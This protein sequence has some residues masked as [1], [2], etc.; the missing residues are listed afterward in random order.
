MGAGEKKNV[1]CRY[2]LYIAFKEMSSFV[3]GRM[4]KYKLV[5]IL[6]GGFGEG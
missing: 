3:L 5:K 2:C 6:G 1:F 4:K